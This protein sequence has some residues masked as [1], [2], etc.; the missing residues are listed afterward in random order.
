[1][2]LYT[3]TERLMGSIF[4]FGVVSAQEKIANNFLQAGVEEV[5]RLEN[6]LSEFMTSSSF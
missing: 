1:M 4:S 3:R 5:M 2:Q 6:L